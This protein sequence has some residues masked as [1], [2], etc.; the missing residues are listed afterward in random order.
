[1]AFEKDYLE[2]GLE[3]L[4]KGEVVE[5]RN[6]TTK[7]L[8]GTQL[9]FDLQE[10]FPI[11][12]TRKSFYKGVFGEFAALMNAPFDNVQ[13]MRDFGVNYWEL[14]SDQE[15][16]RLKVDY[17]NEGERVLNAQG[18]TQMTEV[19][20]MLLN[21]PHSRRIILNYW[22]ADNLCNTEDPLSLPCCWYSLQFHVRSNEYLD[23]IWN[24]RSCDLALGIQADAMLASLFAIVLGNQV[25]LKPG[26]ITMNLGN[27]HLYEEHWDL[28]EMQAARTPLKSPEWTLN[29]P[30]GMHYKEFRPEMLVLEGY[31]HLDPIK[32][33]LKA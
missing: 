7:Q 10:E 29:A 12:T 8:F 5:G 6:G 32:Y 4:K 23:I 13:H 33:L 16:G 15:T 26:K 31:Q 18:D 17:G 11:I 3:I 14:W 21:E 22:N 19:I 30:Q 9:T 1:M 25:G 27:T 24:Q 20:R 2:L 28:F